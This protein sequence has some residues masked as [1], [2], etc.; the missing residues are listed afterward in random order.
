MGARFF[1]GFGMGERLE[2][3][4]DSG[5]MIVNSEKIKVL[6]GARVVS[7]WEWLIMER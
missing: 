3:I 6:A 5:E 1:L 4:N 7:G 2:M